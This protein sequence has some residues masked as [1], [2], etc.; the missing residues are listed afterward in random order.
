[1]YNL[2]VNRDFQIEEIFGCGQA[3]RY[4]QLMDGGYEVIAFSKR[5]RIW[6][7][8]DSVT[9]SC[10]KEAYE[11]IWQGYFDM[12]SDYT[13]MKGRLIESDSRLS[14]YIDRKPGIRI[15]RQA[16][17]EMV[18]TFI[19]SQNKSMPQIMQLVER[20]AET[21][22]TP[23]EDTNGTFYAFPEPDQL[24]NVSE[25]EFRQL[26]V[27]FRAPYLIDAIRH[28]NDGRLNLKEVG[29]MPTASAREA[30]LQV[31]GIGRKVADCI[32]LFGYHRME[33][34]PL[35]V[36]MKRAMK[37]LYFQDDKATDRAMLAKAEE[38]YGDL[39]GLAQQYIF[40]GTVAGE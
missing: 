4:R 3:F 12:T 21:Y 14:D 16:P 9:L 26:K 15:L 40:F 33:V 36:W 19:L 17:F 31:K 5:L 23:Y 35:D 18:I 24:K 1:M 30:L 25:E 32:L 34:F 28:I 20:I 37:K 7:K 11:G 2:Q 6:Q 10:D 8:G 13:H 29:D 27:G 38:I 22:G 39:A